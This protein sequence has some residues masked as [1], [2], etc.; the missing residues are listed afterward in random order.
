MKFVRYGLVFAFGG[1]V[2]VVSPFSIAGA[3]LCALG[4]LILVW[5][6]LYSTFFSADV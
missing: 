5:S 6:L 4:M 3:I 1:L 2:L